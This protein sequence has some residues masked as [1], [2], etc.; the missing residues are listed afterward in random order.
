MA[1]GV[2]DAWGLLTEAQ[3]ATSRA[4][5]ARESAQRDEALA[6]SPLPDDPPNEAEIEAWLVGARRAML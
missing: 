4:V 2:S 5:I 3:R 1:S 6:A